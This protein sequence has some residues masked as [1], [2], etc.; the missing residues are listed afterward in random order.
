M[1]MVLQHDRPDDFVIST[2]DMHTVR[3]FVDIA[4]AMVGRDWRE[5]IEFDPRYLR[6]TEVDELQGDAS[7]AARELGWRPRTSFRELIRLM[8]ESD[9]QEAGVDSDAAF[10]HG[11]EPAGASA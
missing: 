3:E 11:T 5:H 2:G 4:F 9:L 7:K 8:L 10:A 6:P 1:W